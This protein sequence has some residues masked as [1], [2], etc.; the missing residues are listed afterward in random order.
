MAPTYERTG[1]DGYREVDSWDGGFGWV[2]HPD[3][4]GSRT[5]HAVRTVDG[6]YL[7]DPLDAP[8]IDDRIA[9]L[10]DVASVATLSEYHARDAGVFARRYDV[11]VTV[12]RWLSRVHD[13][14]DAS[15]ER[16]DDSLAGFELRPVRP[17]SAWR[18]CLAYRTCDRTLYVPDYLSSH[19]KFTVGSE[20]V[21]LPSL[22]RLDPPREAF[23]GY[24]PNRILFGHGSGVFDDA[25]GA[26]RDC[27]DGARLRAPRALAFNLHAELRMMIPAAWD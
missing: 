5:S 14:V 16:V 15:V 25:E 6:V 23:A 18:E 2:A 9:E 17:L 10:G 19:A 26:L 27:L 22:S 1:S 7:F 13:R 24:E 21:G 3:E 12:P 4:A 11:P 20:R 8:G